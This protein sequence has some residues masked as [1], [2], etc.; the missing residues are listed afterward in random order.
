MS[1]NYPNKKTLREAGLLFSVL[2]ILVFIGVPFL[3]HGNFKATPL[4]ISS[5]VALLS[6]ITPYTLRKP[7]II[8][9]KIGEILG[10]FNS[11]AA[12]ILFFYIAITP[13][14]IIIRISKLIARSRKPAKSFYKNSSNN[15]TTDFQDQF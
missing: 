12:L 7:Y 9:L 11:K 14:A 10:K 3:L 15:Q 13:A 4:V 1:N 5:V 8:W 6:L 2:F